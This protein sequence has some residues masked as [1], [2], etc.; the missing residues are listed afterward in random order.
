VLTA[1]LVISPRRDWIWYALLGAVA[2]FA[3]HWP[4]W[5]VSWVFGADAANLVRAFSAALALRWLFRG[6]PR[7]DNVHDLVLFV[8]VAVAGAPA[9]GAAIGAT[10]VLLHGAAAD[11]WSPWY[12][13]F[14]SNALT[15]LTLLPLCL[16]AGT[17]IR[18]SQPLLVS[19]RRGLE[20]LAMT[21]VFMVLC[22]VTGLERS[23]SATVRIVALFA[24]SSTDLG[25][26]ALR[27]RGRVSDPHRNDIRRDLG[28]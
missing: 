27:H 2:H 18:R 19:R 15:G 3:T 10:N 8:V 17:T 9:L 7:F 22:V 6:V 23:A 24:A 20:V 12:A 25:R 11:F 13:W 4:Q 1:A 21:G 16:I 28:A 14:I 5:S 26:A